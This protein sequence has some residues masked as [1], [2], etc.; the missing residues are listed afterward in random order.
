MNII[1]T[2]IRRL[3]DNLIERFKKISPSEL[4][5]SLEFGFINNEIS[6]LDKSKQIYVVGTAITARIPA[7]DSTMVY[8]AMTYSKPG[9]ILVVDMQGEKRHA[10]WGE[11]TTLT[12]KRFGIG[13]VVVDGPNT[14]TAEIIKNEFPVFSKGF[15]NLT[16]K[17]MGF[18]GDVNVP[19]CCGGVVVCPGDL[20]LANNDGILVIPYDFADKL[21]DIAELYEKYNEKDKE[22][23]E[24]NL[25][26]SE[27]MSFE[28]KIAK[29]EDVIYNE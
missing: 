14:D 16:T 8:K 6:L 12:A 11:M 4:G 29:M 25:P 26:L 3:N 15:S 22:G 18:K 19:I 24:K 13:A 27:I 5:H 7:T 9:D 28:R 20:V 17:I 2:K 1:N 10:C 21:I 23:F